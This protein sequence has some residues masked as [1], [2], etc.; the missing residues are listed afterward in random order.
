MR[1]QFLSI[2]LTFVCLL[3]VLSCSR[4]DLYT[5]PKDGQAA[6]PGEYPPS[7]RAVGENRRVLLMYL[8]GY[9]SLSSYISTNQQEIRQGFIPGSLRNDDVLLVF[10]HLNKDG[11]KGTVTPVLTRLTLPQG[12]EEI[13]VDTLATW[14]QS[15]SIANANVFRGVLDFVKEAFPAKSYGL[16]FS[17]HAT[18]WLPEGYFADP[19]RYGDYHSI[20]GGS[21]FARNKTV[22][23][24]YYPKNGDTASEEIELDAFV[25]A[26]PYHLDF[27]I[28][29]VCL[30][31]GVE[32]AYALKDKVDWLALSPTEVMAH[33]FD[34]TKLAGRLLGGAEADVLGVCQDYFSWY[35]GTNQGGATVSLVRCSE[36][37]RLASVCRPLFSKYYDAIRS[38]DNVPDIQRYDRVMS[39]K[40]YYCFYDLKDMLAFAGATPE[41]LAGLQNA[42]DACL[43]YAR[44]TPDFFFGE[45]P[46]VRCCGL[47]SYLPARTD[48]KYQ[49]YAGT[50]FLDA[51]YKE[52]VAW[53]T[54]TGFIR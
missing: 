24:E 23:Q 40:S 34:Y 38:M 43:P 15:C 19:G 18:G 53:N 21:F 1:R 26:I 16:V 12:Q 52:H 11:Y 33:G 41:E 48:G 31:G 46:L 25:E 54:A 44:Q 17:S 22:G 9:N 5:I 42:L 36:M 13:K 27:I 45:I 3:P 8:A 39:G 6:E 28:F 2:L 50:A 47:S 7:R 35:D 30:M 29:D 49:G 10:T 14:P 32:V 4:E 51:F 37:D 20:Y